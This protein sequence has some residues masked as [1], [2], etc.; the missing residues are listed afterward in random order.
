[1]VAMKLN[2]FNPYPS[3]PKPCWHCTG[4]LAL[5][6]KGTAALCGRDRA[7]GTV[8]MVAAPRRGC[9][10][11]E[12]EVGVD[13]EPDGVPVALSAAETEAFLAERKRRA[14]GAT[15]AAR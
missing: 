6:S 10:F 9:A 4:F 1:M 7:P 13:D 11:F 14:G 5:T 15:R 12:R 8:A 3:D 2:T